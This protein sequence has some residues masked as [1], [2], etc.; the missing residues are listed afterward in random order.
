[1][2]VIKVL[3][4]QSCL[5]LC[6]PMDCRPPGSSIHGIFQA[7]ILEWVVIRFSR[8]FSQS[9]D[10]TQVSCIADRFFTMSEPSE[11]IKCKLQRLNLLI[12]QLDQIRVNIEKKA[13]F[14]FP[15]IC[16]P[17]TSA[18]S[19]LKARKSDLTI[20]CALE[21][22]YGDIGRGYWK[23]IPLLLSQGSVVPENS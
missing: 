21:S 15:F 6:N 10:Q 20:K 9:K 7:R 1:M 18:S 23:Q 4:T 5:T 2:S 13:G 12:K 19:I 17:L 8:G 22:R 14:V 16:A 3:V 11:I